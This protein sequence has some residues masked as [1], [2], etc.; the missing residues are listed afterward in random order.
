MSKNPAYNNSLD[1][2]IMYKLSTNC[3]HQ[4][5][6]QLF[7]GQ[8]YGSCMATTRHYS[9]STKDSMNRLGHMHIVCA[10]MLG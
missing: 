10:C 7:H 1:N 4:Y 2:I 8:D 6:V 5:L 3:G 9:I